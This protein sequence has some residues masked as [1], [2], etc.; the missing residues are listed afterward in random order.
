M[1]RESRQVDAGQKP[2]APCMRRHEKK[3]ASVGML[4]SM[5]ASNRVSRLTQLYH[6]PSIAVAQPFFA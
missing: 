1:L 5:P 3:R 2:Q 4:A 6:K